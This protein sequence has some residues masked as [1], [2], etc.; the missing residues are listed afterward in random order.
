MADRYIRA[1]EL[2][3]KLGTNSTHD[4]KVSELIEL[5]KCETDNDAKRVVGRNPDS[6]PPMG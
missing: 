4:W 2:R 3:P 6:L 1:S 5:C